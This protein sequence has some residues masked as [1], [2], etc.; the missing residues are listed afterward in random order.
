MS[1]GRWVKSSA[2]Y[3]QRIVD[4]GIEGA[5]SGEG[6]FLEDKRLISVLGES[7]RDSMVPTAVGVA[8]GVLIG[9]AIYRRNSAARSLACGLLGGLLGF[10]GGMAWENRRL[11]ASVVSGA[12]RNIGKVCDEQWLRRNPI[13]YA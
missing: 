7:A 13:T 11:G 9:Y 3:G 8:V 10:G 4:A 1:V 12:M 6:E 2:D 5:R